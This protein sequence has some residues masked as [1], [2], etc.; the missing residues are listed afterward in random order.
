VEVSFVGKCDLNVEGLLRLE[1]LIFNYESFWIELRACE[2][3]RLELWR[4]K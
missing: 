3:I 2:L 4:L 1:E